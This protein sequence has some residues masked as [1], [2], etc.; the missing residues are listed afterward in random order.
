MI[1]PTLAELVRRALES[2]IADIHVA[3]PAI[4]RSYDAAKQTVS[5]QP[6]VRRV[7]EDE[8]G[9]FWEEDFPPIDN[10]PVEWPGGGGMY[11]HFPLAAGDSGVLVFC[12]R[13]IAEWRDTGKQATPRDL[14]VHGLGSAVFRPG[15]RDN[16]TPRT[17]AP[18]SG[19][20][21][22]SVGDGIL[23]VGPD[24]GAQFVALADKVKSNFQA[25]KDLFT[26]WTPVPNDGG[27]ALKAASATLFA[28][29]VPS[30]ASEKLKAK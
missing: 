14:R 13:S 9:D 28:P 6:A 1:E 3:T 21:V 27:A 16:K 19:V 18:S 2:R 24:S 26:N 22:I 15:L 20:A 12:E 29:E 5:V 11:L 8:D 30:V 23:R 7:I 10:V 17:D 4:V 25:I